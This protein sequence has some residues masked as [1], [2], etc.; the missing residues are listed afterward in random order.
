MHSV[1]K[2]IGDG[3]ALLAAA[4]KPQPLP[5]SDL[6]AITHQQMLLLRML[7]LPRYI[8][9]NMVI[10]VKVKIITHNNE[11]CSFN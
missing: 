10:Q 3:L 11:K 7:L 9:I 2:A 1:G 8:N 6:I 5:N 4:M